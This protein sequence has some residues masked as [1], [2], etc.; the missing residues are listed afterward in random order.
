MTLYVVDRLNSCKPLYKFTDI[1]EIGYWPIIL[2]K[3][4]KIRF[5]QEWPNEGLPVVSGKVPSLSEMLIMS[6]MI[7][8]I[9][10]RIC[11]SKL[12]G[13]GSRSQFLFAVDRM[14]SSNLER[15]I[16]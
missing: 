12:V 15:V 2:V 9:D 13:I 1:T 10:G 11:V 6:A 16:G 7:V 4:V 3:E 8:T 5:L 14:I